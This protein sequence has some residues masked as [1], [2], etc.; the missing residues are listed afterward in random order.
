MAMLSNLDLIRRVPLFSLLT[1]EQAQGIADSV[2]KRRFRRG[3]IVVEHGK[4]SN[5]LFILLTGR[6]RVLTADS[7]GR[8]VILAVLQSG[9]YVGEM[10]LIDNEPHSATVRAEVQTDMLILGRAEF[11]RCLPENSSLSYAIMRGLVQR[12]RSADRQIESL[13]LLDVYGRVARTLLDMAEMDGEIKVIRNKVSRQDLAKVVGASREMVSRV[14]KDLEGRGMIADPGKRLG[15]HQGAVDRL[16]AGSCAAMRRGG[17]LPAALPSRRAGGTGPDGPASPEAR[18]RRQSADDFSAGFASRRRR[19]SDVVARSFRGHRAALARAGRAADRRR[20]L[21]DRAAR[22]GHAQR[23]RPGLLDLR[24][25]RPD[26][27]PRRRRSAPGCPTSRFFLAGYSVWW[28]IVVGARAWLGA[29]AR[30]LRAHSGAAPE[31]RRRTPAGLAMGLGL[32]LLLAASASLEWTRLYQ[33]EGQVAGGNAGGVLGFFLGRASQSLLGFAGSGVL[34]IAVLVAGTSLALR[35]SWLRVADGSAPAIEALRTRRVER[36]ER[37]EDARLGDEAMRERDEVLEVEHELHE[38]HLPI[39]IEPTLVEVPKSTRVVK[40]RQKP[41]FIELV[42]TKLP[43]VD[44]LDAAPQRVESG[45]RRVARDDLAPDR[46]E[47]QG[48]RRRGA[49]GR[50]VARARSSRATRSSRRSASRARRSSTWPRTWRARSAWSPSAWSRRSP[51]RRRW[52][53]SCPTPSG[54]RSACRRSSAR[55]STPTPARS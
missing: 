40:E 31:A 41:L 14:M 52:R 20:G 9:D 33:W 22:A 38:Q 55:R 8:E 50:G 29:L 5:A 53:S 7:R 35:F 47:A 18:E 54:R 26:A 11:A 51:A 25:R 27:Q 28:A 39:V 15:D 49:R 12:L 2:V 36:I 4:K 44:L 24:Q 13:A 43:Q 23:R 30:T 16:K 19:R 48:L 46:E 1:N 37:A 42:D 17:T 34:W 21:A 45:Q 32:A 3:E 10:S 6:A